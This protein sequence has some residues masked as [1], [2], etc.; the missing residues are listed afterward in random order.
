MWAP[1][2][3]HINKVHYHICSSQPLSLFLGCFSYGTQ[4][5]I[6]AKHSVNMTYCASCDRSFGSKEALDQHRKDSPAHVVT[7]DCEDCNRSFGSEEALDQHLRDC[8]MHQL[9]SETPLDRF[10]RSFPTFDYDPSLPP[11][12]SYA[13]LRRHEGWGRGDEATNDA[14][15][16][17]QNALEG[18][19]RKW[20][21]AENDI[22][23]WHS[24]CRA[25][26]VEPP[27]ET[28]EQCE[29]V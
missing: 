17:Y 9:D 5:R 22:S 13:K 26:G 7:F 1:F 19:L 27:P 12:T 16:R 24:L 29:A 15:D 14:W 18:E 10:F 23:A 8:P 2:A 20:Y 11:A 4:F 25:I 6:G 21:G 28:C 3:E